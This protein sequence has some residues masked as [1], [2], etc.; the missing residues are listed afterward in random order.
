M[1]AIVNATLVMRDHLIPNALLLC[2]GEKIIDFGQG[3]TIPP[4]AAVI[5]AEG[6][7]VGPGLI[8]IHTH[9][10]G[11]YYFYE[12]PEKASAHLL[13]HGVTDVLPAL[14]Y[15]LSK[16]EYL[17]AV[18]VID[19][20]VKGGGFK[21]FAGYYMEGPFLNPNFGC[22]REN[23]KWKADISREQYEEILE[24]VK[25]TAKVWCVAPERKGIREFA[26]HVKREI[27]SIVFSVAHSEATPEQ[28]EELMPYGLRLATHHT[29]AT[30]TIENYPECRGVCVDEAVNYNSDIYAE[31]ICDAKGIHVDPYMLRLIRKIKGDKII[32]ISDTCVFDGPIPPGYDGVYDINFD[33]AGEIAGSKLTLDAACRNMM[34]HTGCSLCDAFKYTSLNPAGLLG[35]ADRGEIRRGNIANLVIVDHQFK[36]KNVLLKGE[37]RK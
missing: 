7:Y 4:H 20:A 2:E 6:D 17:N 9:A 15:N 11:G 3:L 32:L 19:K 24:S 16:T 5:D 21:N 37:L 28:I 13:E 30:G 31:L 29:N 23:N 8:D 36:I 14:Y 25:N 27:P 12:S 34:V 1:L 33:A 22:D 18:A 35:L 26:E 10:G